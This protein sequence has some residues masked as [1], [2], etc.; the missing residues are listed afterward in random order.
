MNIEIT[1][2]YTT[3]MIQRDDSLEKTLMM[4]KIEGRRG[5]GWQRMR[6]LDGITYSM[7]VSL[8][9]TPGDSERRGSPVC[10]SPW[11]RK[12]WDRTWRP[13]SRTQPQ[14]DPAERD[15]KFEHLGHSQGSGLFP[16]MYKGASN[17]YST[18][19]VGWLGCPVS[20]QREPVTAK[21]CCHNSCLDHWVSAW[22][23]APLWSGLNSEYSW[24]SAPSMT[25]YCSVAKSCPPLCD[26]MD[27]SASGSSGLHCLQEFAQIHVHLTWNP[28]GP[29]LC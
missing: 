20:H 23:G 27:C 1:L 25:F 18:C 9:K 7:D 17:R 26:P 29:I 6:W 22:Q 19:L 5:R 4:R 8:N 16:H 21:D 10:C 3:H 13:N 15:P 24:N 2:M 28:A 11:G 12:E 14:W